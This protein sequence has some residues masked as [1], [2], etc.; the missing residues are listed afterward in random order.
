MSPISFKLYNRDNQ[1]CLY[2]ESAPWPQNLFLE[3]ENS[4]EQVLNF[5]RPSPGAEVGPNNYHFLLQFRPGVL[6]DNL[7]EKITLSDLYLKEWQFKIFK[8][9]QRSP[10][11]LYFLKIDSE[12]STLQPNQKIYL[13][14]QNML[15]ANRGGTRGSQVM[16][17][18]R[19]ISFSN[20]PEPL[21]NS[22]TINFSLVNKR[23]GETSPL[24][25]AFRGNNRIINDGDISNELTL[26]LTNTQLYDPLPLSPDS[27]QVSSRFKIAFE[28]QEDRENQVWALGTD[29]EVNGINITTEDNWI[30]QETGS[31]AGSA[32]LWEITTTKTELA[33]NE[34]I[35]FNITNIKSSLPS[36]VAY[37]SL[38]IEN[39]PGFRDRHFKLPI[40]KIPVV[41]R[42]HRVGI[43]TDDP[44]AKLHVKS[45]PDTDG[46]KVEGKTYIK[47]AMSGA[48]NDYQKAQFTMSGGG[49]VTWE[50]QAGRLKWTQRFIAICMEKG[51]SFTT[52]YVDIKQPTTDIP[53][54]H[55]WDKN[56]RSANAKG[57]ILKS[58]EALYAVHTIGGNN[59]AVSYRIVR[60]SE[61][62]E[63]PS[64]WLLVAVVN[65]DDNTIKLGTG[66]IISAK[67]S[68]DRG[69]SLPSGTILMWSGEVANIPDGWAL[70][71]GQK[72]TPNL[73][74]RFIV[75]AG[76][77]YSLGSRG[78]QDNV[79]LNINEMPSHKHTGNT[80]NSGEH[81]HNIYRGSNQLKYTWGGDKSTKTVSAGHDD[82]KAASFY[83][84]SYGSNH[85]HSFETS[86]MGN[87]QA[88]E[89]RPPYYALCFIMKL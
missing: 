39:I 84:G 2:L 13:L 33:P 61:G 19:N 30:I 32:P 54:E 89:N 11:S 8:T 51:K 18:Y 12:Q 4:S 5:T 42:G 15:P 27:E 60:Y 57:V 67:S 21:S 31:D 43:G 38:K 79:K 46:L 81:R 73:L 71:N 24:Y 45:F 72:D 87:N 65:S 17:S 7:L 69:S 52:G 41:A 35:S 44:Q 26:V 58:W 16:L 25:A 14:I 76:N 47:G 37:L 22:T 23:G 59:Y 6:D 29:G 70:C 80:K 3:I 36:G 9:D 74:D 10:V 64:N 55:V 77:K 49:K 48:V 82:D 86:L 75:G 68:S 40:E 34:E 1:P 66:T 85:S 56:A 53:K 50:G 63:A 83:A 28:V 88:H 78:G 20:S 62:F